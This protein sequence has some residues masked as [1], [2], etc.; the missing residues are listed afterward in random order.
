MRFSERGTSCSN[1]PNL[2]FNHGDPQRLSKRTLADSNPTVPEPTSIEGTRRKEMLLARVPPVRMSM[3]KIKPR[4]IDSLFTAWSGIHGSAPGALKMPVRRD[5][6]CHRPK[7]RPQPDGSILLVP[8][9][10]ALVL[11]FLT[12]AVQLGPSFMAG[13][14]RQPVFAGE[15]RYGERICRSEE[16]QKKD[17]RQQQTTCK[18]PLGRGHGVLLG[19]SHL[20]T[21][22]QT[23]LLHRTEPS[24]T[25]CRV[26][27]FNFLNR[28]H[29]TTTSWCRQLQKMNALHIVRADALN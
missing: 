6:H 16:E 9:L 14:A 8:Q 29:W 17:R 3:P 11:E 26:S 13:G 7:L 22:V 4:S 28:T 27:R 23:R 18:T 2:K 21:A 5:S 19:R 12:E 25:C 15:Y 20:R 10:I 1:L 24:T